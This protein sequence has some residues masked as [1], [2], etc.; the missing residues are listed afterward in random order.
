MKNNNF[1]SDE[2]RKIANF[3]VKN[4]LEEIASQL[5]MIIYFQLDNPTVE[6]KN[7]LNYESENNDDLI[8]L[9]KQSLKVIQENDVFLNKIILKMDSNT[10]EYELMELINLLK[11]IINQI[12]LKK[13][14]GNLFSSLIDYTAS[15]NSRKY[16]QIV[17]P[18]KINKLIASLIKIDGNQSIYDPTLGSGNLLIDIVGNYKNLEIYGQEVSEDIF[19]IAQLN[20]YMNGFNINKLK[21]ADVF[22]NPIVDDENKLMTYDIIVSNP[23]FSLSKWFKGIISNKKINDPYNRF[24][25]YLEPPKSRGDYAFILHMINSLKKNGQMAVVV[26]YG[27]LFRSSREGDIRKKLIENNVIDAVIGLSEGL[28][29]D[30]SIPVAILIFRKNRKR[31]DILFINANNEKNILDDKLI[32]KISKTY[33][34]YEIINEFSNVVS[35]EKIEKENYNLNIP[36]Y[37]E[38]FEPNIGVDFKKINKEIRELKN[39]LNNLDKQINFILFNDIKSDKNNNIK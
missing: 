11:P 33:E 22:A 39:K 15:Q 20:L 38:I 9:F 17:T 7:I 16:S 18:K 35:F 31:K 8:K 34:N 13:D 4:K 32:K 5:L 24:K 36:R 23:P 26:P 30:T 10:T 37:I 25:E 19:T 21:R 27:V 6:M 1:K 29:Y 12:S 14:I 3:V 2:M 28:F